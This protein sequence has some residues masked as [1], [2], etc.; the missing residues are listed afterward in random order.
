MTL[1]KKFGRGFKLHKEIEKQL[2]EYLN[3]FLNINVTGLTS[4]C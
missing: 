3:D 4:K 1:I 2:L